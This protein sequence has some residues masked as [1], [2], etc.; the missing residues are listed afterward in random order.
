MCFPMKCVLFY[1]TEQARLSE[2]DC[3]RIQAGLILSSLIT[4]MTL[5]GCNDRHDNLGHGAR[6]VATHE[7]GA[8]DSMQVMSAPPMPPMVSSKQ[9]EAE[10]GSE[11]SIGNVEGGSEG[12]RH[13][14]ESQH[15]QF[16]VPAQDLENLWQTH[17]KVCQAGPGCEVTSSGLSARTTYSAHAHLHMRIERGLEGRYLAAF[18]AAG[19]PTERSVSREDKTLQVV[20]LEARLRNLEITAARLRAMMEVNTHALS[21]LL[22]LERELTRVQSSIDAM[23][24]QRRVLALQTEKISLAFS[25]QARPLTDHDTA[26]APVVSAFH[27]A[28]RAFASSVGGLM[29]FMVVIAPWIV[30]LAP[31]SIGLYRAI[32]W[33]RNRKKKNI[34]KNEAE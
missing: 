9:F 1:L 30:V 26:W 10:T 13:I 8:M 21:D 25:Y 5:T 34:E 19:T 22:A 17:V 27:D 14:A 24:S 16:L 18:E 2:G 6:M 4:L 28:T 33:L 15:W 31:V 3:Q 7:I 23:Q 29:I 32:K 20:D 12:G 11:G